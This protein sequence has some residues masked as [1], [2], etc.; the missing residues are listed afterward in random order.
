MN[1]GTMKWLNLVIILVALLTYQ[2][3]ALERSDDCN[4][5]LVSAIKS[6]KVDTV[7]ADA[8][9]SSAVT[10]GQSSKES[11]EPS[12]F[13]NGTFEGSGNGY[14]GK[15]R[16]KVT[17]SDDEITDIDVTD[18]KGEGDAY[19]SQASVLI[20][21]IIAEQSTDLDTVSGATFSSNGILEA[22]DDALEKAKK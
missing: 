17:I 7:K 14:G 19:Y 5:K 13:N 12:V 8:V 22:V 10:V 4:Q 21:Q 9:T 6:L 20:D 16:V 3:V 2:G 18:H 15:I 1:K 11:K